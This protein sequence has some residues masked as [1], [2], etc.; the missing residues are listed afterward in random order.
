MAGGRLPP[1]I[2][3]FIRGKLVLLFQSIRVFF[4]ILSVALSLSSQQALDVSG[5]AIV[6]TTVDVVD[7]PQGEYRDKIRNTFCNTHV[8]ILLVGD[9]LVG[10]WLTLELLQSPGDFLKADRFAACHSIALILV[11]R[12]GKYHSFGFSKII[13]CYRRHFAFAG[14]QLDSMLVRMESI[15]KVKGL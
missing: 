6:F 3:R 8:H 14:G 11:P 4:K 5:T 2:P 7:P 1:A 13:S 12:R 10:N 15:V 9:Y